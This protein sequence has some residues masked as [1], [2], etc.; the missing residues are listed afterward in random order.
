MTLRLLLVKIER[1]EEAETMHPHPLCKG[2]HS[3]ITYCLNK[4][5]EHHLEEGMILHLLDAQ[6][7]LAGVTIPSV[8]RSPFA[9]IVIIPPPH[10]VRKEGKLKKRLP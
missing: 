3:C 9:N 8:T 6:D 7:L 1:N 10:Q 5:E 2:H 4:K